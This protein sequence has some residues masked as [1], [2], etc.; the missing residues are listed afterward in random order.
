MRLARRYRVAV[1]VKEDWD[2]PGVTSQRKDFSPSTTI[3]HFS[4]DASSVSLVT[5]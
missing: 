5:V 3:H 2:S 1:A 4:F